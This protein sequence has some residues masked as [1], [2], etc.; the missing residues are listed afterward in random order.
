MRFV[1]DWVFPALWTSCAMQAES[2]HIRPVSS[3][4]LEQMLMWR[5]QPHVRAS[6]FTQHEISSDE[7]RQWFDRCSQDPSRCLMIVEQAGSPLGF[8]GFSGVGVGA[9]ATWGFYAAPGAANGAGTKL[10]LTALDFA[11][12]TLQLHKVCGQ[13]LAFN[14]AS[15]RMHQ[16]FGFRQEGVLRQQH[17]IHDSYHDIICFGLLGE[18]WHRGSGSPG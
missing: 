9:I 10:G 5:N 11:F 3:G 2:C 13:A 14:E 18:E 12:Y 15:V 4:D 6:M 16:K 1:M 8:V 7:H 17:R